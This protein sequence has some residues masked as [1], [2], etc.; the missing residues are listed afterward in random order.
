MRVQAG[1][2]LNVSPGLLCCCGSVWEEKRARVRERAA[3]AMV[4]RGWPAPR[5]LEK[6]EWEWGGG[7][8]LSRGVRGRWGSFKM[9]FSLARQP[10]THPLPTSTYPPCLTGF[11]RSVTHSIFLSLFL[12]R[13]SVLVTHSATTHFTFTGKKQ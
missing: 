9:P 3:V 8:Y 10:L 6:W 12:S 1:D 2:E 13:S 7:D 5:I 11:A 4:S